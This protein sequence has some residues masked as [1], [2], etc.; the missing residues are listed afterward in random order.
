MS[1]IGF[2]G[3]RLGYAIGSECVMRELAKILPPY[4]MNWLSL[5]AAK[6]ALQHYDW[7]EEHINILLAERERL[8]HEI[9]QLVGV[10]VY[11][12]QANFITVKFPDVDNVFNQLKKIK[13]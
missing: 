8:S 10:T 12:S 13:F 1:K 6:F 4:N 9:S 7:I 11:P 5:T 3:L 2:A